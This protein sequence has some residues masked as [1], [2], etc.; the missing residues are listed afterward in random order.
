MQFWTQEMEKQV[1]ERLQ[2]VLTDPALLAV[3]QR[4]GG[5]PFRRSSVFHGLAKFLTERRVS[6]RCCFEIGTWNGLTAA[7]LSRFFDQVVTVDI[8]HNPLRAEILDHLGITNVR[9]VDIRDNAEKAA[10]AK[11]L[12]FDFAYMDGDHAH[13]TESDF[14]LVRR[15]GRVLMHEHWPFQKPV[16]DLVN[17]LPMEEVATGGAGLALWEQLR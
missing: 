1:G 3:H 2:I 10:I 7:V 4:F 5:A 14:A 13:D 12:D 15:C 6:G 11:D 16:W 17:S 9:C 8:A